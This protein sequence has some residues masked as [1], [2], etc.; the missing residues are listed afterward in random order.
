MTYSK[1]LS[2]AQSLSLVQALSS[3]N[4]CEARIPAS[5]RLPAL[6][7]KQGRCPH[8]GGSRY[9]RFDKGHS[10]QRF[11]CGICR[12]YSF[13]RCLPGNAFQRWRQASPRW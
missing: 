5:S 13:N 9:Y 10:T 3:E 4:Q 11:K 12:G 8:C 6:L 1:I 7:G 2:A